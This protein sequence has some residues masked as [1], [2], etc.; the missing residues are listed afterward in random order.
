MSLEEVAAWINPSVRGWMNYYGAYCKS[1]LQPLLRMLDFQL[2]KWAM[3]KFKRHHRRLV[4]ALR[5]L[6]EVYRRE[7]NL[8]AHHA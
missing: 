2:A 6:S 7:P 3:R 8:F 1:A 5:W 4:R